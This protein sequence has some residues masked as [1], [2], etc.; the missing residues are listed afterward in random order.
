MESAGITAA[1]KPPVAARWLL[2]PLGAVLLGLLIG[3]ALYVSPPTASTG[4]VVTGGVVSLSVLALALA[5]YELAA[6]LGFLLTGIVLTD[7]APTDLVF[8]I[9][10][11]V[12]MA[13]GRFDISRVPS[14]VFGA[15][16]AFLALNMVS[17]L[18]AVDTARASLYFS[19]TLYVIVF[20]VWLAGFVDSAARARLVL[21]TYVAAATI[22][23]IIG[24]LALLVPFP[25]SEVLLQEGCC[26]AKGLFQDANVYGPFLIPAALLMLQETI[27]PRLLRLPRILKALVFFVLTI[28]VLLSFSR[29]AWI[30]LAVA[31][32]VM[33]AVMATRRG[34]GRRVVGI[35]IVVL[36]GG[37]VLVATISASGNATFLEQRSG[38]QWYDAERFG[39]QQTGLEFAAQYPI[40][41]G[42]GQ[43]EV[44]S[45][46]STHSAYVRTLA[47]QG[48][49]GLAVWLALMLMT[50]LMAARNAIVGLSTYG[51]GSAALLGAW[52]G[53]LVNSFAVDTLHWR[54]LWLVA[55]LIWVGFL[56]EPPAAR[57]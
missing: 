29:G 31:L 26:R 20:S 37:G 24:S 11:S 8:A 7:P 39:A 55:A 38:L 34:G 51:I 18:E 6:G 49:L 13:T 33:M 5:R 47:E 43:F 16:L 15:L 10:I 19:I 56:R 40:G 9:V 27:E 53:L 44:V 14:G 22:S 50:L 36:L 57:D 30:N 45:S 46:L 25:G 4:L 21:I 17:G 23:A 42:P 28:G 54:H 2:V 1:L 32:V 3:A 35:V 52:C 12:A 48:V 41:I